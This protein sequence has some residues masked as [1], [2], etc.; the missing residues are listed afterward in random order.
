MV[1]EPKQKL[2]QQALDDPRFEGWAPCLGNQGVRRLTE[3]GT[4]YRLWWAGPDFDGSL[5]DKSR[6]WKPEG[7]DTVNPRQEYMSLDDAFFCV[8][9]DL[10]TLDYPNWGPA[11]IGTISV[12]PALLNRI[13]DKANQAIERQVYNVKVEKNDCWRFNATMSARCVDASL[14]VSADGDRRV[15]VELSDASCPLLESFVY[16]D[17][18][19]EFGTELRMEVKSEW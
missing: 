17:L 5:P 16:D 12:S 13:R 8:E 14:C 11:P 18:V 6:Q 10:K 2:P 7:T 1:M 9:Q 19:E 4:I 15:L 3:S